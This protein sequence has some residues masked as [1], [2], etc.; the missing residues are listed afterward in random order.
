[1]AGSPEI[2][3]VLEASLLA[4][5]FLKAY[6]CYATLLLVYHRS[7]TYGR[8]YPNQGAMQADGVGGG[9]PSISLGLFL[10]FRSPYALLGVS[11]AKIRGFGNRRMV[12][13]RPSSRL[14]YGVRRFLKSSPI[15]LL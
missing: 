1:M 4:P 9:K 7:A 15:G 2:R 5:R 11:R 8:G 10:S 14:G 6:G 12:M 3:V 13:A